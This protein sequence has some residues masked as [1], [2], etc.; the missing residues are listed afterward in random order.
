MSTEPSSAKGL[1]AGPSVPVIPLQE[2]EARDLNGSAEEGTVEKLSS[3]VPAAR[4]SGPPPLPNQRTSNGQKA[5]GGPPPLAPRAPDRD[6]APTAS[7]AESVTSEAE[8]AGRPPSVLAN[9][10]SWLVSMVFHLVLMLSLA[11]ICPPPHVTNNTAELL[12]S[13]GDSAALETLLTRPIEPDVPVPLP[14]ASE[15]IQGPVKVDT[16]SLKVDRATPVA[17]QAPAIAVD[18]LGRNAAASDLLARAG[19]IAGDALSGRGKSAR[20]QMVT[21][22]GGSPASEL[23]VSM[24]LKWLAK[25]RLAD[26][27][28][29]LQLTA[30]PECNGKCSG[31]GRL[32]GGR[33]AATG[34]ALLP[35]LGAGQTHREGEY[36]NVV[37]EGL[38]YLTRQIKNTPLGGALNEP[39]GRMY[40]HG[41]AAI[42]LCEAYAMTGDKALHAPAQRVVDFICHVQD[43]V[44]G[45]WRYEPFQ[46]GDTS[47]VGWQVMALKSALFAQLSVPAAVLHK[48]SAFLDSVQSEEGALYGYT[49]PIGVRNEGPGDGAA[50]TA[51]GLLCRMHLGWTKDT[52]ALKRGVD[53]LSQAGPVV[54]NLYYDYYATQVMRHWEGPEWKRWNDRMRDQLVASQALKGHERGS[55]FVTDHDISNM[56]GG[57]LY[58]T[59]MATMILEV[60]YRH[61]PIYSKKTLETNFPD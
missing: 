27:G 48:A 24:A 25:H 49:F 44:G 41:I 22:Y 53:V 23:A 10:P 26:G 55:W 34:L 33:I 40:S 15:I 7:V 2:S 46:R 57:R 12:A 47:V 35:F 18:P 1:P 20:N 54:G 31:S 17:D 36:R 13:T 8:F 38:F 16:E 60:Y 9:S 39:G 14:V 21:R 6:A 52:P 61:M 58:C 32:V 5:N 3:P 59:A 37:R 45:G 4:P 19:S 51:I 42:T 56:A 11:L 50:T 30:V 43:P 29:S 28:W